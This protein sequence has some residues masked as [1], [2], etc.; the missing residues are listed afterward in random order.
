MNGQA[1]AADADDAGHAGGDIEEIAAGGLDRVV[2][3]HG[4]EILSSRHCRPA[5][6][7]C[8]EPE[9][10]AAR[11]RRTAGLP[12]DLSKFLC[13]YPTLVQTPARGQGRLSRGTAGLRRFDCRNTNVAKL[14][15]WAQGDSRGGIPTNIDP[16]IFEP[17]VQPGHG[18]RRNG[19][20]ERACVHHDPRQAGLRADVDRRISQAQG[21][22]D[23]P[24]RSVDATRTATISIST[25]RDSATRCSSRHSNSTDVYPRHECRFGAAEEK[26]GRSRSRRLGVAK[27]RQQLFMS[28]MTVSELEY[29]VLL[30][31]RNDQAQGRDARSVV[32]E[33]VLHRVRR[34]HP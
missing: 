24:S 13:M 18:A 11:Q 6:P 22:A 5:G 9:L 1:T 30:S 29:G 33:T 4:T 31:A 26:Q 12:G 32:R 27:S 17:R 19:R 10:A 20:Q 21:K 2:C 28:V 3:A 34:T 15:H 14:L 7:A 23:E 16:N 8:A 25:P